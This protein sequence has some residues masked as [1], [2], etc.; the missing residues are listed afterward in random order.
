MK[1]KILSVS[2]ICF[3]LVLANGLWS[4]VSA[5]RAFVKDWGSTFK[6]CKTIEQI[7]GL[8]Q[9]KRP[10]LIV[11]RRFPNQQW[12]AAVADSTCSRTG[13]FDAAVFYD[14]QGHLH[15]SQHHFC[16]YEG[17]SSNINSVKGKS[18][19]E[20]YGHSKSFELRPMQ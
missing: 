16:G 10:D 19:S 14:S 17:L 15:Q 8:P 1:R 20:F 5:E 3:I 6:Q 9:D 2:L 13:G 7:Q 12:V 18:L 11:I 4:F